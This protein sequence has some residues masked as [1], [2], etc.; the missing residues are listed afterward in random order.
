M[1]VKM[2]SAFA[3][4]LFF[5]SLSSFSQTNFDRVQSLTSVKRIAFGSCNNQ[6]A[7]QPLWTDIMLQKPDLWIWGGDIIY[8]DWEKAESVASGYK[9]LNEN[10]DYIKFKAQVPII[11]TWDDHDYASDNA[12]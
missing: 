6:N 1:E 5:I 10:P 12:G 4:S 3:W 8:A 9:M 2:R 11:G 7:K